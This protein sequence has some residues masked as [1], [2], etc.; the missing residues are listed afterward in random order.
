[1]ENK[2]ISPKL[3]LTALLLGIFLGVMGIHRFYVGKIGTGILML[4]TFG[5]FGLWSL[6]D[7]IIIASG[8][9]KDKQG[10]IILK[11]TN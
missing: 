7:W 11:W 9:F 2:E 4:L 6:V 3:R 10:R 1:M 5:G 8:G